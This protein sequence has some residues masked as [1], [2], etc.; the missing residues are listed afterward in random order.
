LLYLTLLGGGEGSEGCWLVGILGGY[1]GDAGRADCLVLFTCR[2]LT[3]GVA[4]VSVTAAGAEE[5]GGGAVGAVAAFWLGC[6]G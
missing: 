1:A 3:G 2:G 6:C 4:V 5:E